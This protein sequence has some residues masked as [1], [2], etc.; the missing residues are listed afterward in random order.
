M[1]R[2]RRHRQQPQLSICHPARTADRQAI[3]RRWA[4]LRRNGKPEF[5]HDK[6]IFST[7]WN[8]WGCADQLMEQGMVP[9][10][11][12]PCTY[13]EKPGDEHFHLTT[14]NPTARAEKHRRL[15]LVQ[16]GG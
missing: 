10:A 7:R 14:A 11:P 1:P 12:Y 3:V 16:G 6:V 2:R 15:T 13:P 5:C 9:V 8:A 4:R